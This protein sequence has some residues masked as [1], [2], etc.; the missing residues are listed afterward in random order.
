MAGVVAAVVV[1]ASMLTACRSSEA[2]STSSPGRD[3]LELTLENING[4]QDGPS[5]ASISPDGKW[6]AVVASVQDKRGIYLMPASGGNEALQWW[7]EGGSPLWSPDGERIA[8][9]ARGDLWVAA[10][11]S[12]D[13]ALRLTQELPGVRD[14][15]FSPDG[16]LIA[17]YANPDSAQDI[18]VVPSDGSAPPRRLVGAA[19]EWDDPRFEPAW[20]PDGRQIAYVSDKADYWSDDVWLVDVASGRTRQLTRKLMASSTPVWSPKGDRIALFG[21]AKNEYW[22]QDLAYIYLVDPASPGSERPIEMQVYATDAIMRN[23]PFWSGDGHT[24]YFP[25]MQRGNDD[26]WAVADTGGVATQVTSLGGS[27]RSLSASAGA[28][29]FAFVRSGPVD[30]AEVYRI[31]AA[32]GPSVRLTELSPVWK[33]VKEPRELAYRSFDG[34]YIQ[35]FLFL[36]PQAA[37]GGRC[38]ALVNVHGGGT[39]SYMQ[40]LDLMEQYLASR[41]FVVLAINYRGGSGFGRSFQ[42]LAVGDWMGGQALDAGAAADFLRGLQYVNGKV[43][44]FGGS[45]GGSTSLAAATR[46]PDKFDAVVAMRGAYAESKSFDEIDRL[47]KI[48]TKTGHGA[49]PDENPEAYRVSNT[50]ERL[51]RLQAPLLLMHGEA[52]RRVP[53]TNYKVA[54][55]E[56]QRLG[57][58]FESHSY[59]GE[60]HGF[61]KLENRIDMDRRLE[62]FFQQHL[63]SCSR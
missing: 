48:F 13:S 16:K 52:D 27:I 10:R 36:P 15:S 26:L 45:Y 20:S 58:K 14:P 19:A 11:A 44:I 34:M 62:T 31:A 8:F 33:G 55:A 42:D 28:G 61:R 22:Y 63:G 60:G 47:G 49:L 12:G 59:P 38:P 53:F 25:Y 40:R 50:V 1:G 30:G 29:E 37:Q 41:G 46:T 5:S 57:K 18:W 56:L 2:G 7:R 39:N 51:D 6:I 21:T 9:T 35:G 23:R 32:G 43:G 17:F 54:V 3:T 4:A 24:I